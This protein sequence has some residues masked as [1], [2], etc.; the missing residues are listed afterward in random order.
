[1]DRP[2]VVA[3][4]PPM[5]LMYHSVQPYRQDPYLVT[6][7][8]ARFGRQVR[9]LRRRGLRGVAM[10]DLLAAQAAGAGSGLVGLT[11]DDGYADFAEHVLPVLRRNDFTATVFVIAGRVGGTNEWDPEGPRKR[12]LTEQQIRR[13]AAAGME[14]GSHGLRHNR[15]TELDDETLTEE[16][17]GSREVLRDISGQEVSGFCYPYGKV[18]ARIANEV[19]AAGYDY[20]CAIEW[21]GLTGRYALPRT[22]VGDADTGLRLRAK[23]LRHRLRA[24]RQGRYD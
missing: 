22:Y 6:V 10:R 17:A 13:A 8:P 21:S 5:V 9:W 2:D 14:I 4:V 20:G 18:D 15:L 1:V 11:F 16:I 24:R 3:T 12:L 7:D 19:R 23:W